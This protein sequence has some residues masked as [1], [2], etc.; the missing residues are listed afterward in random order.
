VIDAWQGRGLGSA[1]LTRLSER[2]L[3]AGIAWQ[4]MRR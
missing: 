3:E 4:E 2:A 1:L